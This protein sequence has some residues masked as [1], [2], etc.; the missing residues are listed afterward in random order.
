MKTIKCKATINKDFDLEIKIIDKKKKVHSTRDQDLIWGT[1]IDFSDDETVEEVNKLLSS[2]WYVK[3]QKEGEMI[4]DIPETFW[5]NKGYEIISL[6]NPRNGIAT[7][8]VPLTSDSVAIVTCP[9][10]GC[11]REV[12]PDANYTVKCECCEEKYKVVS[13]L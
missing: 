8:H 2:G 10:C 6:K 13:M 9:Y 1:T 4:V 5:T 11:D 12:E 3:I 7:A